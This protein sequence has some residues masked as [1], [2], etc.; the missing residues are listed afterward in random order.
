MS[1]QQRGFTL[2]EMMVVIMIL[3]VMM[4]IATQV[5]QD[6][7]EKNRVES[8][9]EEIQSVL[10]ASRVRALTTGSS[11]AV[12]FDFANDKVTSPLW[13]AARD[14][15]KDK[16]DLVAYAIST[17]SEST[18]T[19]KTVTFTSRGTATASTVEVKSVGTQSVRYLTVNGVTGRVSMAK[20]C[21]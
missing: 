21:P 9:A 14:Y 15:S 3:A 2:V 18:S 1:N 4:T 8:A 5:W 6:L 7:R 10:S 17:C 19:D 13:S 20:K 16:I 12:V 11:Q